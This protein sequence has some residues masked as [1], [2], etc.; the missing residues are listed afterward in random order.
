MNEGPKLMAV[1][2]SPCAQWFLPVEC[3]LVALL[4]YK[5]P[6]QRGVIW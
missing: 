6:G 2:L 5:L 4:S 1:F 3:L